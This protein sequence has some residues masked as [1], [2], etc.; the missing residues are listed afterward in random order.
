VRAEQQSGQKK[1]RF[2]NMADNSYMILQFTNLKNLM[3]FLRVCH[4]TNY[5]L[6]AAG[7]TLASQF[8]GSEINLALTYGATLI[9]GNNPQQPTKTEH[10]KH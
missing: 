4:V 9:N 6:N 8:Q 1:A 10:N 7:M 2:E 3:D 5:E